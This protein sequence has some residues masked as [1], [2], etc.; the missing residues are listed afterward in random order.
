MDLSPSLGRLLDAMNAFQ[1]AAWCDGVTTAP[2]LSIGVRGDACAADDPRALV[3]WLTTR[4]EPAP[5]GHQGKTKRDQTVRSTLR[6][7]AR[8]NAQIAGLDVG[9]IVERIEEALAS[10]TRISATL[11]DVLVYPVGGK[12][13]RHKDTPRSGDQLGTLIVE[14]PVP[15]KGGKLEL[16]DGRAHKTVDWSGAVDDPS[17]L[18]WVAM[19]GDVDHSI[20]EVKSGARVTLVYTL[21]RTDTPRTDPAH[22]AR[23]DTVADAVITMIADR[24]TLPE[25]GDVYI[26]CE[27]MIVTATGAKA[28][29]DLGVLR[30]HD[31]AIADT[32]ARCGL[33]P[34]VRELLIP[35]EDAKEG[36]PSN[37]Y[38]AMGLAKP[39]P[40][41]LFADA[42]GA[43]SF[44]DDAGGEYIE[45]GDDAEIASIE[46]YLERRWIDGDK[47][48]WLV[49]RGAQAKLVYEGLYSMTGY[50]G[51]EC[52]DGHIYQCAALV[53]PMP[54][55][56]QRVGGKA[57]K[58]AKPAKPA[59][60]KT[61]K[62]AKKA[63]A[64]RRA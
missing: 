2:S 46:E 59:K 3:D 6:L 9:A 19:F 52:D 48:A 63:K 41:K 58:K 64:R 38:Y 25:G 33:N 21:A 45:E 43:L 60:K 51:N 47:D 22:A 28:P 4:S 26:P 42:G 29:Y 8:G 15:H 18:R 1:A 17:R 5:F 55:Y 12:F 16:E 10:S 49:R 35:S 53:V 36:F 56:A 14:V 24:E 34:R 62:P 32:F 61:A 31:R 50:F 23:L 13:L 39:I 30:G 57:A 54:S 11:L 7:K 20:S 27:H 44:V 37:F 40:E